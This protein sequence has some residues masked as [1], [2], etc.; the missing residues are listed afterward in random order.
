MDFTDPQ[1]RRWLLLLMLTNVIHQEREESLLMAQNTPRT[2]RRPDSAYFLVVVPVH[3]SART[4]KAK[5]ASE[6]RSCWRMSGFQN[7]KLRDSAPNPR[8]AE[9]YLL[10]ISPISIFH[11]GQAWWSAS[12]RQSWLLPSTDLLWMTLEGWGSC[13]PILAGPQIQTRGPD[14]PCLL[15]NPRAAKLAVS[16]KVESWAD[17]DWTR[18]SEPRPPCVFTPR[19]NHAAPLASWAGPLADD[20]SSVLL[21]QTSC[22]ISPQLEVMLSW[23]T[24]VPLLEKVRFSEEEAELWSL[25]LV[26]I[27]SKFT[28]SLWKSDSY[29]K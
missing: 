23:T 10:F 24:L 5:K 12:L 25:Q 1:K 13:S 3:V 8:C 4:E 11:R 9:R 26:Q 16:I 22:L 15:N 14:L 29:K 7:Q 17:T 28:S 19:T 20:L 21:T 2:T 18:L 6:L 27:L